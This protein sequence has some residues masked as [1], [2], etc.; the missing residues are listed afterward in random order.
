VLLTWI[1]VE[2]VAAIISAFVRGEA[3]SWFNPSRAGY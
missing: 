2:L 1:T 3:W